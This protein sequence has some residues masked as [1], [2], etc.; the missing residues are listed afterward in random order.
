MVVM[1]AGSDESVWD[2][3]LWY[4]CPAREVL[5][6]GLPLGNGHFG[7]LISGDPACD[8]WA[9]NES[10]LWNAGPYDP[11]QPEAVLSLAQVRRLIFAGEYRAAA[12]L[13]EEKL[14]AS[15]K[16]QVAYQPLGDLFIE[17]PGHGV[18]TDYRRELD[19]DRAMVTV[20]Y[21]VAGT[22]FTREVFISA[23]DKV[24]VARF[25]A[26]RAHALDCR[27]RVESEQR[28]EADW[29]RVIGP[30]HNQR[31]FGIRGRNRAQLGIEAA[32]TFEF[33]AEFRNLGG[34]VL[35]GEKLVTVRGADEIVLICA[36]ATSF[37]SFKDVGLDPQQI[38]Q[39]R[40]QNAREFTFEQLCERHLADHQSRFRRL[41]IEIGTPTQPASIP[42]DARIADFASGKD[43][44]LAAL[45]VQYA[46]Y[47]LLACSRETSQPANLQGLW[48]DK[49]Q[50]PWGS[51]CTIN[52]NTEMNYWPAHPAALPECAEPLFRLVEDLA[53]SGRATAK[54]HYGAPGWVAHHN[55]DL[56]RA[57]A[58]IDGVQ[59]GLW[60]MGGAWLCL[61]LWDHYQFTLSEDHLRRAYPLL[62]G[63]AEFF[64]ASLVLDPN[65]G[66]RVTCP[67]VS[68][69]NLHPYGTSI[70]AGPTMDSAIL[71]DLFQATV[72]AANR[73]HV[74][75]EFRGQILGIVS[76]LPPY[77]IGKGGQL[78]EWQED[79]DLEAPER[80]HRHVSHLFGLHPSHQ[81]SPHR[82]PELAAAAR[83]TLELRGDA[84]TGWSLAWK[85][86]FWAR[87]LDGERAYQLLQLLLNPDHSFTNLF[88]SHPPFQIDGNFGGAAGILEMLVQSEMGRLHL[89]PALPAAWQMGQLRGAR[90][91]GGITVDL[92][93]DKHALVEASVTS[94]VDQTIQLQIAGQVPFDLV[95]TAHATTAIPIT[96]ITQETQ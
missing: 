45:Y 76:E 64:V 20:Q 7:A 74:D 33:A 47:L 68:P 36:C 8:R 93:W 27:L 80:H 79:W 2:L 29:L 22:R 34:R 73:L 53:E 40:L 92:R 77:R 15:P 10:T 43:P 46:R 49:L 19:L 12:A 57:T 39:S 48:N 52:I 67:S 84:A 30:W 94:L 78:Q 95:V 35:P 63:A 31:G 50:P 3:K 14:M 32:L 66:H 60:P 75:A 91:R 88:D 96:P 42:T 65:T 9:L 61:H 83:R 69:E 56:W 18:V 90:A 4:D 1:A 5:T 6:E 58:P 41:S 59:W 26:T 13:A 17:F 25:R 28:P 44:A 16:E 23:L 85:A 37:R 21:A 72:E 86:N 62:K 11:S 87:L 82:T 71:R 54:N 38:V 51:K 89:L 55:T 24:L 81:I 70:C